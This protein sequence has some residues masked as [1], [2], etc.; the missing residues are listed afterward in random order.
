MWGIWSFGIGKEV[1]SCSSLKRTVATLRNSS[2]TIGYWST[3]IHGISLHFLCWL[4]Q[5]KLWEMLP[6]EQRST[7]HPTQRIAA[8]F[9]PFS[10]YFL[11]FRVGALSELLKNHEGS[12][13][14]WDEW[15]GLVVS[16]RID[17]YQQTI[18]DTWVSGCRLF[19]IF[20]GFM[21]AEMILFDFSIQRRANHLSE[22]VDEDLGGVRYMLPTGASARV[23]E[24]GL[25]GTHTG[26]GNIALSNWVPYR[27]A[28]DTNWLRVQLKR[29]FQIWSF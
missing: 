5:R 19:C 9:L 17:H 10:L 12:E 25:I 16:S 6:C 2:T 18:L 3:S 26:H 15:R 13:I 11:V 24:M 23:L 7:S 20:P 8:L 1:N 4:T 29:V 21:D 22:Q 28:D 14:G 27:D